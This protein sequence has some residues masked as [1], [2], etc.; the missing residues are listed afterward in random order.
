MRRTTRQGHNRQADPA[1]VVG[2]VDRVPFTAVCGEL[3]VF[4]PTDLT[5]DAC[6]VSV[7]D[8]GTEEI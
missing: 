7:C 4:L 2:V 6:A 5:Q 1:P 3:E 8:G